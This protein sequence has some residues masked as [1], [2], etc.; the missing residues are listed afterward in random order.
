MVQVKGKKQKAAA[1]LDVNMSVSES[2][3]LE[4]SDVAF[5]Y[6]S[7]AAFGEAAGTVEASG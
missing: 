4:S 2:P 6:G 1:Y 7:A 5:Y 3:P